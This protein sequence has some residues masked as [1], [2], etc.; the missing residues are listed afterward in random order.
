MKKFLAYL[1]VALMFVSSF[2]AC[3]NNNAGNEETSHLKKAA[4]YIYAMYKD[5]GTSTAKDF[6]R[7]AQVMI[8]TTKYAVEW[9]TDNEAVKVTTNG[10]VS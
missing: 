10:T 4:D 5:K 9:T 6:E 8:G 2:A 3:G 7:T 1:L